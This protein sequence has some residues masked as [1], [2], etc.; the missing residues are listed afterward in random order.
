MEQITQKQKVKVMNF[1]KKFVIE[2][3]VIPIYQ[4]E[5]GSRMWG[6]ASKDSD[7]D[8]RGF[9]LPIKEDYFSFQKPK[10]QIEYLSG[11]LDI[12]SY[13]I[14]KFFSLIL[15]SNPNCLEQLQSSIIYK[16]LFNELGIN[17]ETF[18]KEIFLNINLKRL[19]FHYL[20]MAKNNYRKYLDDEKNSFT[21]KKCLYVLR[22]LYSSIYIYEK[23][24]LPPVIFKNLISELKIEKK[25]KTLIDTILLK[26]EKAQEKTPVKNPKEIETMILDLFDYVKNLEQ[27]TT[28]DQ[29]K[30]QE[31]LNK[32]SITMK[33]H[34]YGGSK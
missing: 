17:F 26:K 8:I 4:I 28:G 13:S 16:N 5:S 10:E 25:Y 20:S 19:F 14:D 3:K 23:Q 31:C 24:Q 9:H 27:K 18:K 15:T 22:S 30:L 1:L 2:K 32:V 34:Y 11:D 21:Y 6:F 12:V 33:N 7:F 29:K